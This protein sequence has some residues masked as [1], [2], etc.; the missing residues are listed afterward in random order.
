MVADYHVHTRRCGHASGDDRDYAAAGIGSGLREMGF[1][2]HGP[3]YFPAPMDTVRRGMA[4]EE[5][6]GYVESVLELKQRY[7]PFPIRLGLE[8]DYFPGYEQALEKLLGS[9]PFDYLIGS[10]HF[11]PEWSFGYIT[12][13]RDRPALEVFERYYALVQRMAST[14]IFQVIGHLDLPRRAVDEPQGEKLQTLIRLEEELAEAIAES[15]A[16][17]EINTF[18]WRA[19]MKNGGYPAPRLLAQLFERRIPITFGSDAHSPNEVGAGIL[20]AV[21]RARQAGYTEYA[22]FRNRQRTLVPLP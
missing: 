11:I 22:V 3:C 5:L 16:A 10:V 9:Y 18:G 2:D 14:K 1:A 15:G 13:Y 7:K 17:V 12:N 4:V 6:E 20:E 19:N 8:I 21:D